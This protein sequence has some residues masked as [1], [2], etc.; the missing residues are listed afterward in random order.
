MID[1]FKIE[2]TE[3]NKIIPYENNTKIHPDAQ[4][5]LIADSIEKFNFDQPIVV[6]ED[7]IVIKGHG[8]L[9]AAQHLKLDK[10]P[11]IIRTD[12]TEAQK[13]ASRIAD[14]K[15]NE[16]DWDFPLLNIELEELND[17]D[18]D[19]DFGFEEDEILTPGIDEENKYTKKVD[20]PVYEPNNEKP[21][22][23][24]LLDSEKETEL[25]NEITKSNIPDKEK[26]FL[27]KAAQRHSIFNYSK[28]ADYYAQSDKEVQD[29]MEKSA[30]VIID[31]DKAIEYGYI[32]LSKEI[33]NQYQVDYE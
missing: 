8:R 10:V 24:D 26:E 29:L 15:S 1:K 27:I 28:I 20:A 25:I 22:I 13:I 31:F 7:F 14:N 16:S 30:L 9:L 6:D 11:V 32:K 18:F 5:K 4:I 23:L 33:A 2:L 12:L 17:L 3:T 19:Y 21:D